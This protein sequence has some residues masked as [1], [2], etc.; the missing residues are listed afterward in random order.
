[1]RITSVTTQGIGGVTDGSIEFP[2]TSVV[3]IA[4]SNGT[5][6]SKLLAC[7][8]APWTGYIP[9][10]VAG[11]KSEVQISIRLSESERAALERFEIASTGSH[12]RLPQ[13]VMITFTHH[14]TAGLRRT[15]VP[16]SFALHTAFNSPEFI[17]SSPS[18]NL[19]YLPAERRLLPEG[20]KSIDLSQLAELV[21]F[22]KTAEPRFAVQNYGRLDDQEFESFARA[23]C[24]AASLPDE[25]GETEESAKARINWESFQAAVNSIIS[26]KELLPLT[27]KHPEELRVST[28]SG[29]THGVRDLSSGERQALV[30]ISRVL[31]A[32]QGHSTALVD[33]PDAYL[34]P[35]LSQRLIHA[36][37]T[38]VGDAGQLIVATHSPAVLDAIPPSSIIRMSRD[39]PPRLISDEDGRLELY[40]AAGFRAS[41]LTQSDLLV[42]VEGENDAPLLTLQFPELARASIRSAGGRAQALREVAQLAPYDI[43]VIGAVDRDV[44]AP[45]PPSEIAARIA[46][47]PTGDIEGIYL[48]EDASLAAMIDRRLVRNEFANVAL[49]RQILDELVNTQRES[50]IA[51]LAQ[52]RLRRETEFDWPSPRGER[53]I[54]RLERAIEKLEQVSKDTVTKAV[55]DATTIWESASPK[56]RWGLVRAKTITNSFANRVSQMKSGQALLE[57]LA[58]ERLPL[59]GFDDFHRLISAHLI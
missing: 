15:T 12:T 42:I 30:V 53:P 5:G 35:L 52:R 6:K 47:W 45:Q 20:S 25:P 38:G 31:R 56:E 29:A 2:E 10:A 44:D 18:L 41:S 49:L 26:P 3:A 58:R 11:A 32:G 27:R 54:E 19:I 33:E 9:S 36:L 43:P 51:E 48:S 34:H 50:V 23:L 55:T 57:A 46:I 1:M 17:K 39:A 4:G 24:V 7:L 13:T 8:L 16:E 28:P 22:E 14:P 40:R 59:E 21:S 37:R